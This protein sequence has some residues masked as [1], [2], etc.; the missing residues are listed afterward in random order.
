MVPPYVRTGVFSQPGNKLN[1]SCS[2]PA[3]LCYGFAKSTD[4]NLRN[5][6]LIRLRDLIKQ[7]LS[8]ESLPSKSCA[9]PLPPQNK[10]EEHTSE[11]NPRELNSSIQLCF[12]GRG[13]QIPTMISGKCCLIKSVTSTHEGVCPYGSAKQNSQYGGDCRGGVAAIEELQLSL[14]PGGLNWYE[15][16]KLFLSFA[17]VS[18]QNSD[19]E[20][21]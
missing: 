7:H 6:F 5:H 10:V 16:P 18:P 13:P 19:C 14:L 17:E 12:G 11:K 9:R 20:S 21:C 8:S 2:S 15:R 4:N 3:S 1:C